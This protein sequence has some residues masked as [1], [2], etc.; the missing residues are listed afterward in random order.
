MRL[1]IGDPEF[2]TCTVTDSAYHMYYTALY[3]LLPCI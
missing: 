1:W 3:H 2:K